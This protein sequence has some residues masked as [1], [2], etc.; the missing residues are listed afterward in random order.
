RDLQGR[1]PTRFRAPSPAAGAGPTAGRL[2]RIQ[3][4]ARL[5]TCCSTARQRGLGRLR[6]GRRVI[7][8]DL[9]LDRKE[10]GWQNWTPPILEPSRCTPAY[11]PQP[12]LQLCCC[13]VS[14]HRSRQIPSPMR[15]ATT[16]KARRLI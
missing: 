9:V 6:G 5:A 11:T 13:R 8:G 4:D 14:R 2:H 7:E 10:D 12:S 3:Q 15:S 16:P 1:P